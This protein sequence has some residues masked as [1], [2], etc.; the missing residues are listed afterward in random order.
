E[1]QRAAFYSE[2]VRS[3]EQLPG[4]SSAALVNHL[5]LGGSNSSTH[6]LVEGLPEPPPGQEFDGRYR[7]CT[8]SYFQTMGISILKGRAFT[9]QDRAG[10]QPVIIV[11]ETLARKYWPNTDPLGK[12]MRYT[13]PLE[14]NPWMQVV[15]VVQDVKHEMNL[16]VTADFY[17]PH[18]QDA[19]SEMVLVARTK[20]EP[21]AMA[22]PIRQ[23][24]WAIDKDQPVFD[25]HTMREVRAISL[26]LYSFSSVMLSIFAGVALL[27]AAIGIYGVMFYAVTQR[28]QE[29]GIRMALGARAMDVLRL[30]VRN[31][32][33]LALI[34]VAV[35]LAGAYA[36]TRLLASLL[37]GV[38]PTDVITF[39]SVTIGLLLTALLACY[40]P[41]RRA[42]KV[43]PME[44][45]RYE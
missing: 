14:E 17:I 26:A 6:F 33:S 34:G 29:I 38:T 20:V 35:G 8:P 27:L 30:I 9:Q 41:A 13:G 19:W 28:T 1:P 3:V 12:R 36:L 40:I 43:D 44:A 4:V 37:F 42:T 15:G 10:S 23:Q 39:S 22:A 45:L 2:L 32:M 5:P 25:V 31:G 16:P 24:V 7:V 18:A 21:A 11:N